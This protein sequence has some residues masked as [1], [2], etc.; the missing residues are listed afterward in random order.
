MGPEHEMSPRGMGRK[1]GQGGLQL[2]AGD[3]EVQM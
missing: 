2:T 3:V 1:V